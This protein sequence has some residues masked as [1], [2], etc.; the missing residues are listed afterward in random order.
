[1]SILSENIDLV[2]EWFAYQH[3][4]HFT[5]DICTELKKCKSRIGKFF[6]MVC[7]RETPLAC[8]DNLTVVLDWKESA[9]GYDI[10]LDY[11]KGA[12]E[13]HERLLKKHPNQRI[14]VESSKIR[15]Q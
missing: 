3:S 14:V 8:I 5:K 4:E 2:P 6:Y 10:E 7:K 1:M 11:E 13:V 12:K 9:N 15:F